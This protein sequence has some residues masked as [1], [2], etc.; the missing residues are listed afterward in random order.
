ML[1]FLFLLHVR[2]AQSFNRTF[3]RIDAEFKLLVW[4]HF[5]TVISCKQ[6]FIVTQIDHIACVI[7]IRD[8]KVAIVQIRLAPLITLSHLS[9]HR[10]SQRLKTVWTLPDPLGYIFTRNLERNPLRRHH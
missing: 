9:F 3:T 7:L 8:L 5:S 2:L 1:L 6:V 4:H 10:T